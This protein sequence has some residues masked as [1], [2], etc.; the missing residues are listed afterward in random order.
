[1]SNSLESNRH[2]PDLNHKKFSQDVEVMLGQLREFGEETEKLQR[3]AITAGLKQQE[4][5]VLKIKFI[6]LE[7]DI[8]MMILNSKTIQKLNSVNGREDTAED[9]QFLSKINEMKQKL[10]ALRDELYPKRWWQFWRWF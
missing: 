1:M 8:K 10:K 4:R 3:E 6:N 9:R 2:E 7:A 5:Q